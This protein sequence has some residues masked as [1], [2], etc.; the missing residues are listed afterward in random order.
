MWDVTVRFEMLRDTNREV[1]DYEQRVNAI[2]RKLRLPCSYSQRGI[3]FHRYPAK[4]VAV[5]CGLEGKKF[6]M[7][8]A[9]SKQWQKMKEAAAKD[10]VTIFVKYAFRSIDEQAFLIRNQLSWGNELNHIL[11]WIAAP[12]YSEHHTGRALDIDCIPSKKEFE[13]T[14]AFD[15]LSRNAKQFGFKLSYAQNNVFGFIFEPWHWCYQPVEEN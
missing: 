9:T 2:H 5:P 7:T 8:P 15:W 6:L 11:T 12:G 3:P 10:G 4:L 14:E 13:S 1:D